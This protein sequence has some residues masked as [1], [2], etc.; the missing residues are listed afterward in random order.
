MFGYLLV[1]LCDSITVQTDTYLYF[2]I[3]SCLSSHF[4]TFPLILLL[5]PTTEV[6]A[7]QPYKDPTVLDNAS[8]LLFQFNRMP[9]ILQRMECHEIAFSWAGQVKLLFFLSVAAEYFIFLCPSITFF[10]AAIFYESFSLFSFT[11]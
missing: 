9:R 8:E 3:F 4:H 10:L 2:F 6:A 7:V 5:S 11:V 1:V